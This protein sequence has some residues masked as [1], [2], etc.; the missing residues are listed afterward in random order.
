MSVMVM[1]Q[2]SWVGVVG[3]LLS[4]PAIYGLS[5]V[6]DIYGVQVLLDWRMVASVSG[7]TLVMAVLSGL[8]A[9]RSL[10]YVEPALL[11]R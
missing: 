3:V 1:T 10:K 9:L 6:A 7:I 2:A 4:F 11:L 8:Y 5:K